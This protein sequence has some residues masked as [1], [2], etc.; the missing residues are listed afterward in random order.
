MKL[1]Y[2]LRDSAGGMRIAIPTFMKSVMHM[3]AV[4]RSLP[5]AK[6]R[7]SLVKGPSWRSR[8]ALIGRRS[9]P[10]GISDIKKFEITPFGRRPMSRRKGRIVIGGVLLLAGA[11]VLVLALI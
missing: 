10:S 11:V 7:K 1:P 2:S 3:T 6:L 5:E 4:R 8:M 9:R